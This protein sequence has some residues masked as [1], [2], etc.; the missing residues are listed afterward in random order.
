MLAWLNAYHEKLN[1]CKFSSVHSANLH[2]KSTEILFSDVLYENLVARGGAIQAAIVLDT[3]DES[4]G[5]ADIKFNMLDG[6]LPNL[7]LVNLA[8]RMV[9]KEGLLPTIFREVCYFET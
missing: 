6:Q 3:A 9:E 5:Q 1:E 8:I 2:K 4:Y 7:D